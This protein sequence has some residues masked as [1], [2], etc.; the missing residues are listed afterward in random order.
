MK[1]LPTTVEQI[2]VQ[3]HLRTIH[4]SLALSDIS[5]AQFLPNIAIPNSNLYPNM[6]VK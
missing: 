4:K 1:A 3:Y 2:I 5:K 6:A